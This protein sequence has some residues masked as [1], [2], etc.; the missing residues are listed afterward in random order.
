[1][2]GLDMYYKRLPSW[3]REQYEIYR[4]RPELLGP[5][6][7]PLTIARIVTDP[8]LRSRL[9]LELNVP[10]AVERLEEWLR[11]H[12]VKDLYD[13]GNHPEL[14]LCSAIALWKRL[15]DAGLWDRMLEATYREKLYEISLGIDAICA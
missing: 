9:D 2:E 10:G 11:A 12:L 8:D 14:R 15:A 4:I 13:F 7:E 1:M 6:E 3:R 5:S